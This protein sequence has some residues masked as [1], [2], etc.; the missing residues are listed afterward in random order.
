VE[1]ASKNEGAL[2]GHARL[3]P[4]YNNF[5]TG[6]HGAPPRSC[7]ALQWISG[8]SLLEVVGAAYSDPN[9]TPAALGP[10]VARPRI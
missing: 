2:H 4:I 6:P 3:S 8:T 9:A 10:L 1:S 7:F 5:W